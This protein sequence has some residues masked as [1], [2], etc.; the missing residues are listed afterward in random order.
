MAELFG[1][2]TGTVLAKIISVLLPILLTL[3]PTNTALISIDQQIHNHSAILLGGALSPK[4][5]L[6][7]RKI[8]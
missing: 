1:K 4:G 7:C 3:F 6:E 2:I 8:F 5:N